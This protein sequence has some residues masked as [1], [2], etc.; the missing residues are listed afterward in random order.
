MTAPAEVDGA[1]AD[2]RLEALRSVEVFSGFSD[3]LLARLA[4]RVTP[5]HVLAGDWL[6]R[7][8][9]KADRLYV[10]V[11]GRLDVI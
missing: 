1:V 7:Q 5:H 2:D 11:S 9:E 4:D 3:E 6:I 8:G 10:V